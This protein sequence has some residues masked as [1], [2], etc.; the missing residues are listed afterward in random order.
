MTEPSFE[1]EQW[2]PPSLVRLLDRIAEYRRRIRETEA[3]AKETTPML[4]LTASD[5]AAKLA[6]H[7]LTIHAP[8]L[9][10]ADLVNRLG[11]LLDEFAARSAEEKPP[12]P[13]GGPPIDPPGQPPA[14]PATRPT[15]P[16][17]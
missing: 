8:F 3:R 7:F 12:R 6:D 2:Y 10:N 5:D 17:R 15:A 14:T 1:I 4:E 11:V 16:H 13:G 9:R